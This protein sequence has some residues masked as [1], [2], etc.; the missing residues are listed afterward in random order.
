MVFHRVSDS[1]FDSVIE[2][3]CTFVQVCTVVQ[4]STCD[5][6]NAKVSRSSFT[7]LRIRRTFPTAHRIWSDG[8]L[9]A[10]ITS[11]LDRP[12]SIYS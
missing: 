11:L 7:I 6:E 9:T 3:P 4:T 2:L 12:T 10:M 8:V 1:R 5:I